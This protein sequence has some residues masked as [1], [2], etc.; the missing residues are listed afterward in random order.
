MSMLSGC[1]D[2]LIIDDRQLCLRLTPGNSNLQGKSKK[3]RVSRGRVIEGKISN[4]MTWGENK[5][6]SS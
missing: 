3:V 1:L 4:E 5:F 6:T 2:T